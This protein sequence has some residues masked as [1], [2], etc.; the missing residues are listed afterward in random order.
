M[1]I[2]FVHLELR[3]LHTGSTPGSFKACENTNNLSMQDALGSGLLSTIT[4]P[5]A[6][7]SVI[8]HI[9]FPVLESCLG[10]GVCVS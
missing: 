4:L 8:V 3:A 5:S 6:S 2:L 7:F 10:I 9:L 1:N